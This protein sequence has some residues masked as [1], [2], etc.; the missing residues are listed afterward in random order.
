MPVAQAEPSIDEHRRLQ[1]PEVDAGP[2]VDAAPVDRVDQDPSAMP[3]TPSGKIQKFML[4]DD[5][6][7]SLA[8]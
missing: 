4:H 3:R 6:P 5:A 1:H 2:S 7:R 8:A